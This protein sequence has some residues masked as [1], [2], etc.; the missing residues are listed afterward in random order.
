MTVSKS[1]VFIPVYDT[2]KAINI[3]IFIVIIIKENANQVY[4]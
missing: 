4:P 1:V 3:I 2:W